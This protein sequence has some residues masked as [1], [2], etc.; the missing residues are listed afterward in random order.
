MSSPFFE[1]RAFL[2][3]ALDGLKPRLS[4]CKAVF[5]KQLSHRLRI[6]E[7]IGKGYL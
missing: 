5:C 3:S 7:W 2:C 4:M 6:I 1:W